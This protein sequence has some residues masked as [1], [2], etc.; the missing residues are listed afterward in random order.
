MHGRVVPDHPNLPVH[1]QKLTNLPPLATT[2]VD[3]T[4]KNRQST[5]MRDKGMRA[6]LP[7]LPSPDYSIPA[8]QFPE[9]PEDWLELN[10]EHRQD[11]LLPT[12]AASVPLRTTYP[13][14][15]EETQ[16]ASTAP[17]CVKQMA[18]VINSVC[19]ELHEHANTVHGLKDLLLAQNRDV[20]V[21]AIKKL[22]TQESIY[23]DIFSE[24]ERVFARNYYKQKKS[25][26][27]VNNNGYCASS[28]LKSKETT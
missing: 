11:Y 3:P 24:K 6:P 8:E 17:E 21:L 5:A 16:A 13:L 4:Q 15:G 18:F 14:T 10:E 28:I 23:H 1:L 20:R 2:V 19:M 26:M 22:L 27:F 7:A 9:Y 12:H 25:L